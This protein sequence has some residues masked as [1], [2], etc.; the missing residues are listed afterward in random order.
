MEYNSA[1]ESANKSANKSANELANKSAKNIYSVYY[2]EYAFPKWTLN[3]KL[4]NT[5][6]FNKTM[7]FY[8]KEET[9]NKVKLL[10]KEREPCNIGMRHIYKLSRMK[11]LFGWTYGAYQYSTKETL[12]PNIAIYC[13]ATV[14]PKNNNL[15]KN[16][17]KAHVINLIGYA[18]DSK[19]QPDFKYFAN[20]PL[21]AL[22]EKYG[23]MWKKAL[24]CAC[25]LHNMGEINKIKIYNVGGG[26][27][28]GKFFSQFIENIFEPSFLPLL[29]IFAANN[30]EVLGYDKETKTFN[31]GFIPECLED[32]EDME[33]TLYVNAWDPWSLIGNGN[34]CDNS[35]DGFW[36]R[37]TNMAVLGWSVTNPHIM[38]YA[39]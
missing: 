29:P 27:F 10:V 39:V 8:D 7:V 23:L 6:E 30:I 4:W 32:D 37:S 19:E 24:Y 11:Q 33:H 34:N 1:N 5:F 28:A 35:L 31:G 13:K 17:K 3:L 16:Y 14:K 36:G 2:S 9:I 18:F 20:K 22:V 21:E 15:H 38:Y 12:M 25:H 26:S